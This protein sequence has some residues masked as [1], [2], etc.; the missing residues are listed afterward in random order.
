MEHATVIDL[1][2]WRGFTALVLFVGFAVFVYWDT[3]R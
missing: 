2:G 3:R 1:N